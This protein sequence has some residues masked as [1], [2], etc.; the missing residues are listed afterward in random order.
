MGG[1]NGYVR[2]A[3]GG[4]N[5]G[6]VGG[7]T[8]YVRRAG[9]GKEIRSRARLMVGLQGIVRGRRLVPKLLARAR[10]AIVEMS[11]DG[12]RAGSRFAQQ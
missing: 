5:S 10:P 6:R 3:G 8:G 1:G 4:N 9:G 7:G 12:R 2:R 11:P